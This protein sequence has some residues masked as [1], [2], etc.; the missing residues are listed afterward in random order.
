MTGVSR[1]AGRSGPPRDQALTRITDGLSRTHR[2]T[3]AGC[4]ARFRHV[5]VCSAPALTSS[6]TL[7][8]AMS[9]M[10]AVRRLA[11]RSAAYAPRALPVCAAAAPIAAASV[12]ADSDDS[13]DA[14]TDPSTVSAPESF[15]LYQ[16]LGWPECPWFHRAACI[17]SD[18]SV[19]RDRALPEQVE[20]SILPT[21]RNT[22]ARQLGQLAQ[23]RKQIQGQRAATSELSNAVCPSQGRQI[24]QQLDVANSVRSAI[25]DHRRAA[26]VPQ[27]RPLILCLAV[28]SSLHLSAC[29]VVVQMLPASAGHNSCPAVVST[30]CH[31]RVGSGR[32]E[33]D[34]EY[35]CDEPTWVGGYAA[36]E[37]T[38]K[39]KYHF[40][41]V[42]CEVLEQMTGAG[43]G[44]CPAPPTAK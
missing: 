37:R 38:I 28:F 11:A 30:E 2:L 36:L 6:P 23:V 17:A 43:A 7:S 10:R 15:T 4:H 13:G 33:A 3:H 8:P 9:F 18:L 12:A 27:P 16:V 40:T 44:A 32:S 21:D 26:L 19:S 31:R 29:F 5:P 1:C 20:V 14:D 25:K 42:R 22:F 41:S 35:D 34:A 39:D 24:E